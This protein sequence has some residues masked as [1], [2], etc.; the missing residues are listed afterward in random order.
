MTVHLQTLG[1]LA[2]VIDGREVGGL[3]AQP[4]RASLLVFLGVEVEAT[5][6][7]V[8]ACLWPDHDSNRARHALSQTLYQ[9]RQ[10]L[11]DDWVEVDGAYLRATHRLVVDVAHFA[12]AVDDARLE[13][14]LALY[15]GPFLAGC[16][17][18]QTTNFESWVDRRRSRLAQLHRRARQE[19]IAALTRRG[20]LNGALTVARGWMELEPLEE[21]PRAELIRLLAGSGRRAEALRHFEDFRRLLALED[22]EP[23]Q[24]TKE[25]VEGLRAP[26]AA[27]SSEPPA[28]VPPSPARSRSPPEA[29]PLPGPGSRPPPGQESR[30]SPEARSLRELQGPPEPRRFRPPGRRA[31]RRSAGAAVLAFVALLG[32]RLALEPPATGRPIRSVAVLPFDD[33]G[34]DPRAAYFVD[35]LHE[36]VIA[37]LNRVTD[38]RVI[39]RTSVLRYRDS[40]L[41]AGQIAQELG[42][43]ALVE[44][45]VLRS[46]DSIRVTASL[47]EAASDTRLGSVV[48]VGEVR[49]ILGLLREVGRGVAGELA[50]AVPRTSGEPPPPALPVEPAAYEAYLRARRAMHEFSAQRWVEAAALY[51][52]SLDLDS[53]FAPARAGL[54][55]SDF[56][57]G[58]FGVDP[59]AVAWRRAKAA[60]LQALESNATLGEAHSALGLT[61]LYGDRDWR[62]A[63]R[64]LRR[65]LE[66]DPGDALARH[67]YADLLTL[68]GDPEEGARQVE[69]GRQ[70]DPL[71]HLV[72]LTV[73]GHLFY[74]GRFDDVLKEGRALRAQFPDRPDLAAGFMAAALWELERRADA[75]EEF[76]RGWAGDP[77]LLR[78][79][80][81]A[82]ARAGPIA[83][84]RAAAVY[85]ATRE[86]P[87]GDVAGTRPES[88]PRTGPLEIAARFAR[89]GEPD[90]ALEWLERASDTEAPGFLH[91]L[92]DPTYR[93]LRPSPRFA[94]LR[95]GLGLP[96]PLTSR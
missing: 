35:G 50:V 87:P 3:S 45:A 95:R 96:D 84:M 53:T 90:S 14:A 85:A 55:M 4:V 83:A 27:P 12:A 37:E 41:T 31:L 66:L 39:A 15:R 54:A 69:M 11:G 82:L 93:A 44:G 60:A 91:A 52:R 32:L 19:H 36:A 94:A 75:I 92:A 25:L 33:L 1:R 13:E 24:S 71:S 51:R 30:P 9:L 21:A 23:S 48:H 29:P 61:Y 89:A 88:A 42:V 70:L 43:D 81:E 18:A 22:L 74:A 16:H 10:A 64:E 38:L 40:P 86:K 78:I 62:S 8:L 63:E 28:S 59:P 5:R 80:D 65:A 2:A 17:L 20:D 67:G 6:D 34:G 68:L 79:V 76:R 49:E 7:S 46:G 57:L 26:P 77:E 72:S 56:L 58:F 73:I 47:V